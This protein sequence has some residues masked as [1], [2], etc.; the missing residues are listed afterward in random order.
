VDVSNATTEGSVGTNRAVV[1][2]LSSGVSI[3]GPTEGMASELGRSGNKRV[4]LFNS[5]P[6]LLSEV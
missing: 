4:L 5:V 2:S 1:G 3:V 6:G